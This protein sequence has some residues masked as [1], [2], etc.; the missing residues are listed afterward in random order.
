[1]NYKTTVN[2]PLGRHA[3]CAHEVTAKRTNVIYEITR[4]CVI[5]MIPREGHSPYDTL[6]GCHLQEIARRHVHT[7][8]L[9][10][11]SK[12]EFIM[13]DFLLLANA[14]YVGG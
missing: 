6:L 11:I 8:L 4:K 12:R 14:R 2:I 3:L 5:W 7:L 10:G 13:F 9:K 1:M